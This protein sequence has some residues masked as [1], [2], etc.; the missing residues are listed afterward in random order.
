MIVAGRVGPASC[1]L[2]LV[3]GWVGKY[4]Q[5]VSDD[6]LMTEPQP[7]ERPF[8]ESLRPRRLAEFVGQTRLSTNLG[9]F[10]AAARDRGEALDHTLFFGPP[11]LG[12]TTLA[13]IVA[14]EMEAQIHVT[15]GPVLERAGDL[16]AM[17]TNL[18]PGDV[19]FID[20][21]HRL[22]AAVEEILYPAMEDYE[23]DRAGPRGAQRTSHFAAIHAGRRN[24]SHRASD[25]PV[26]GPFW[27]CPP[28]RVLSW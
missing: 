24:H 9:V 5:L 10:I 6:I 14:N 16:A 17:L 4:S 21:I 12:K 23:L 18:Q 27:H 11:G 26:A 19:L 20:E 22:P 13:H 7:E 2:D 15:S 8:E 3:S 25:C 28:P 1:I